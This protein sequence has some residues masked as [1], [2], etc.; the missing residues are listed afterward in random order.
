MEEE[1]EDDI[2]AP[3]EATAIN[4]EDEVKDAAAPGNG[5]MAEDEEEGEEVEEEESDSVCDS[6]LLLFLYTDS[7]CAGY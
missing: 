3:D 6:T 7:Y 1:D 4:H 5:P 2:Y